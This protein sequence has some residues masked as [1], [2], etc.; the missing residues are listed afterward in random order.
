MSHTLRQLQQ[1]ESLANAFETLAAEMRA[2]KNTERRIVLLRRMKVLIDEIDG[3][4]FTLDRENKQ[5][6]LAN[7]NLIPEESSP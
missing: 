4:I 3:H 7:P 2:C 6:R 5:P 1:F